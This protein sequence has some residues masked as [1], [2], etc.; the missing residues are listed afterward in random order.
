M[1]IFPRTLPCASDESLFMSNDSRN[2][3]HD[4]DIVTIDWAGLQV[5]VLETRRNRKVLPTVHRTFSHLLFWFPHLIFRCSYGKLN[6][7]VVSTENFRNFSR[8]IQWTRLNSKANEG[9]WN[10]LELGF[11]FHSRDFQSELR[12][13]LMRCWNYWYHCWNTF[14][15]N[16]NIF[17]KCSRHE[18]ARKAF[19]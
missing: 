5:I 12:S 14:E 8:K 9:L 18:A 2:W 13:I 19:S 4:C 15:G 10:K 1:W 11:L 16:L 6:N 3:Q 17:G 7:I